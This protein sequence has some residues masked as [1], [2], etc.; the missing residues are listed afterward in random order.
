[1][2]SRQDCRRAQSARRIKGHILRSTDN[3]RRGRNIRCF[4]SRRTP[5]NPL[6]DFADS[7]P[8]RFGSPRPIARELIKSQR[9][10]ARARA[11]E[12]EREREA[13]TLR[14]KRLNRDNGP[15]PLLPFPDRGN[16]PRAHPLSLPSSP[17][18]PTIP[19]KTTAGREL[20]RRSMIYELAGSN[21]SRPPLSLSLSLSSLSPSLSLVSLGPP[22]TRC[23]R[24]TRRQSG[25]DLARAHYT[26]VSARGSG[27]QRARARIHPVDV[28]R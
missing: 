3:F 28:C 1:M 26:R 22:T 21:L 19:H 18:P 14:G 24:Q 15:P 4:I 20:T 13:G 2:H 9:E 6:A 8:P 12:R 23:T 7:L 11:R 17:P 16:V 5:M 10:R 25:R 27:N